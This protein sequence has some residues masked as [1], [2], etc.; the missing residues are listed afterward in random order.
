MSLRTPKQSSIYYMKNLEQQSFFFFRRNSTDLQ[1]ILPTKQKHA[2]KQVQFFVFYGIRVLNEH[3][4][5]Y[6]PI[7]RYSDSDVQVQLFSEGTKKL[8]RTPQ[9]QLTTDINLLC[10]DP[11]SSLLYHRQLPRFVVAH[12]WV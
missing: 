11:V 10:H 7:V 8:W 1:P 6:L 12:L 3:Y 2:K 9:S 4:Y 5:S